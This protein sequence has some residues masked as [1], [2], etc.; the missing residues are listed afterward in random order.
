M[1]SPPVDPWS[2]QHEHDTHYDFHPPQPD[3]YPVPPAE[4]WP[5]AGGQPP[6]H[7]GWSAA[8]ASGSPAAPYP[9]QPYGGYPVTPQEGF[10]PAPYAGYPPQYAGAPQPGGGPARSHLNL[11]LTLG[12]VGLLVLCL[13]GGAVGYVALSDNDTP[14]VNPTPTATP[15]SSATPSA[16]PSSEA[17]PSPETSSTPRIRVVTPETLAGRPQSTE[18]T[19]KKLAD[20]MVRELKTSVPQATGVAGAFYGSAD[21]RDMVM[22][23]AASTFV[24]NPERE[25]DDAVK[26]ISSELKVKRLTN[27]APGP[28]GGEARCGDGE[29][30]D[31]PLG[32]C[33]WADHGSVGIIVMF[34]SS[35]A[36]AAAEFVAIRGQIEQKY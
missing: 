5:P 24:L 36:A 11:V 8:P 1:S 35:S 26:G 22:V 13:G 31:V 20:D 4:G 10:P 33:A 27:I 6:H 17:A 34:F 18:P 2:G 7:G 29:S 32:V 28:N 14:V 25:L 9:T 15:A 12:I 16:A 19:L 30:A 21:E 23:V 3:S